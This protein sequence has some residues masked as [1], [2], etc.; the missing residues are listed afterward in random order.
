MWPYWFVMRYAREQRFVVA[1]VGRPWAEVGPATQLLVV[2]GT[3]ET[4]KRQ[5]QKLK[6]LED[7]WT[8]ALEPRSCVPTS[9]DPCRR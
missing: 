3:Q 1:A 9:H 4:P 8:E 6:G 7:C 5:E 2:A